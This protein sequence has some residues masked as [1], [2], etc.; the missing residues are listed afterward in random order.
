ML[1][2]LLTSQCISVRASA[3][4]LI[5]AE[6]GVGDVLLLRTAYDD[7]W[8]TFFAAD[9]EFIPYNQGYRAGFNTLT[10][11][12]MSRKAFPF[13]IIAQPLYDSYL[14]TLHI[15]GL[16]IE[17][18]N[19][20]EVPH[21]Q[22]LRT[23]DLSH[24]ALKRLPTL[25]FSELTQLEELDL[26]FNEISELD[27]LVFERSFPEHGSNDLFSYH[28]LIV[29]SSKRMGSLKT[30]RLN[31]NKLKSIHEWWFVLLFRLATLTMNDNDIDYW[32]HTRNS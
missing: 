9:S 11:R 16:G 22:N 31:N 28:S 15:S 12:K 17:E 5:E 3:F 26:S 20:D 32:N 29:S 27:D 21:S 18:Y 14:Q 1:V 7:R 10:V 30:I 25:A 24:N 23:L 19:V 4:E 2:W 6:S 13:G 8:S